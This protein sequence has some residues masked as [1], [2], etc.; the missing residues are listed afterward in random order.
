MAL[1]KVNGVGILLVVDRRFLI[2]RASI[3][4]GGLD[5]MQQRIVVVKQGYLF[6]DLYDHAP[7]AIMAL[8]PG[9]TALR[10]ET[11]NYRNIKRPIYPLD[12][13]LTWSS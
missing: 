10:L 8:S 12:P 7:R 9:A 11:L 4:E 13:D 1:F 3:A 6:P 2:D 5:P